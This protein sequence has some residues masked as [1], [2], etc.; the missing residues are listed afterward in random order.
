MRQILQT[1]QVQANHYTFLKANL[2]DLPGWLNFSRKLIE[3]YSNLANCRQS[4]PLAQKTLYFH[5]FI[6]FKSH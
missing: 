5:L 2:L 6:H 1:Q 4:Q 3:T